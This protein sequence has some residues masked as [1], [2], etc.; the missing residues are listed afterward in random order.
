MKR[1]SVCFNS[2][3]SDIFVQLQE[4]NCNF[5]I[6]YDLILG[7]RY[8]SNREPW[9]PVCFILFICRE[10]RKQS[11]NNLNFSQNYLQHYLYKS[12]FFTAEDFQRSLTE[13][14]FNSSPAAP[15]WF[16]SFKIWQTNAY[17][18]AKHSQSNNLVSIRHIADDAKFNCRK[19]FV[20]SHI[21][22]FDVWRIIHS[23]YCLPFL[24]D[25]VHL[26]STVPSSRLY[27]EGCHVRTIHVFTNYIFYLSLKLCFSL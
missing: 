3:R 18:R 2:S 5:T 26:N 11:K 12:S 8:G 15:K 23:F 1:V 13:E 10:I 14:R 7:F 27:M 17:A 22:S 19:L 4:E 25:C 21:F 24:G 16:G 20:S 6:Q 9:K